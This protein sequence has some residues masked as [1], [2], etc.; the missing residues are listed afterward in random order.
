MVRLIYESKRPKFAIMVD[1]LQWILARK[2]GANGVWRDKTYHGNLCNLLDTLAEHQFRKF[3]TK[4][5]EL[6]DLDRAVAKTYRLI[7]R[8]YSKLDVKLDAN[9]LINTKKK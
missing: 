4:V 9:P 7:S 8:I 6:K 3:A 5:E 2:Q 1:S